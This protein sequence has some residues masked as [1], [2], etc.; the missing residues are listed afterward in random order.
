MD[1]QFLSVVPPT[2]SQRAALI[3]L[4]GE[5]CNVITLP[6]TVNLLDLKVSVPVVV[7]TDPPGLRVAERL[8]DAGFTVWRPTRTEGRSPQRPWIPTISTTGFRPVE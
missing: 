7:Q 1:V 6:P 2:G 8:N 5:H 4:F 3:E